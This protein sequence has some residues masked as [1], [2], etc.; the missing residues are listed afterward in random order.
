MELLRTALFVVFITTAF[1]RPFGRPGHHNGHKAS[2]P[3][4]WLKWYERGHSSEDVFR[5]SKG[6]GPGSPKFF[7]SS[8]SMESSSESSESNQSSESDAS[9]SEEIFPERTTPGPIAPATVNP[10]TAARSTIPPV[11]EMSTNGPVINE[12]TPSPGDVTACVTEDILTPAP[13]T[14]APA[15]PPPV[16]ESRGDRF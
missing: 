10:P 7:D 15:T 12:T 11:I 16:T 9:S 1:T 5:H 4:E 14:P 2:N 13:P 6:R 8:V 3:L